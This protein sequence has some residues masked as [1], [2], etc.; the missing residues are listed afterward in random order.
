MKFTQWRVNV[1]TIRMTN[2]II[3]KYINID[4]HLILVE[5]QGLL[6]QT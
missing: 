5:E 2:L 3:K 1:K 4:L 6:S